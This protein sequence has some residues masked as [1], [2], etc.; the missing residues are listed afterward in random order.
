L[1]VLDNCEHIV[2]DVAKLV[3]V[4]L[5]DC[6][7]LSV[8]A[9]SR[10]VLGLMGESVLPLSPLAV[11][12]AEA[13]LTLGS[14]SAFASVA[15]F[16][17]RART[18]VHNFALTTENAGAVGRVCSRLEGLPLAIELAAARLRAM[19]IEQIADGLSNRYGLLT[20]GRR[21]APTRQQ[22][23]AGCI[24]WSYDL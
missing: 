2:G 11:P 22:T 19:S 10:E 1:L 20:R 23:L 12:D 7:Q 9:T 21:G 14:L 18:A 3:D 8:L 15:L 4:L 17:Q 5:R 24:G 13:N 16:V 6:S